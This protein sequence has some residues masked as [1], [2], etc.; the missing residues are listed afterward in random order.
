MKKRAFLHQVIF[1]ILKHDGQKHIL[2]MLTDVALFMENPV[3][4]SVPSG[5]FDPTAF[6][7]LYVAPHRAL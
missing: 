7:V 3:H 4:C 5:Y 6:Q 2:K 1:M